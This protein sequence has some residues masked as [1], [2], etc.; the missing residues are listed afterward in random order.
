V[1]SGLVE[2]DRLEKVSQ[3]GG[4]SS[5]QIVYEVWRR[6]DAGEEELR[7]TD[8]WSQRAIMLIL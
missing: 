1:S 3:W 5:W 8:I 2:I 7:M 4:L 6:K